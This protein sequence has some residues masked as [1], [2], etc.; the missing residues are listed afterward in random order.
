MLKILKIYLLIP[1]IFAFILG[2]STFLKNPIY[3][4][5]IA[6]IFFFFQ[7]IFTFCIFVGWG[8]YYISVANV[9]E[10]NHLSKNEQ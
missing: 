7:F 2:V 10:F 3:I 8:S 1:F 9:S 6:K 5:R 4:R